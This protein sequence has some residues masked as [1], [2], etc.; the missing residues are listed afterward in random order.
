M[1]LE[2]LDIYLEN[3]TVG[4]VTGHFEKNYEVNQR[5][6]FDNNHQ[7]GT[8]LNMPRKCDSTESDMSNSGIKPRPC[9]VCFASFNNFTEAHSHRKLHRENQFLC[10]NCFKSFE[11]CSW[12]KK[13]LWTH[14]DEKPFSCLYCEKHFTTKYEV[15]NHQRIHTNEQ[16]YGCPQCNKV[17]RSKHSLGAHKITHSK[18]KPFSCTK[19]NKSCRNFFF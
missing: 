7:V 16:P 12:L 9:A 4:T 13:H 1:T 15:T 11:K 10:K 18:G 8:N 17:F 6:K 2:L 19:C 14:K 5:D 3:S